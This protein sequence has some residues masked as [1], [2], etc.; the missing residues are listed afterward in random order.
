MMRSRLRKPTSKS[1][2]AVLW[3]ASARPAEKLALVVVLPTPPLPEVMTMILAIG[4][5]LSFRTEAGARGWGGPAD[6]VARRRAARWRSAA[7]RLDDD[8][9]AL[10]PHDGRLGPHRLGPRRLGGA[11]GAGDGH[12]LRLHA[13]GEDARAGV[14]ARS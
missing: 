2:T 11:V 10:E 3:P 5:I 1:M 8:A 6:E 9:V 7:D 13:G 4:R 12:Q 14:A